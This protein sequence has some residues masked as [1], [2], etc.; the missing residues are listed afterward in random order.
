MTIIIPTLNICL[1]ANSRLSIRLNTKHLKFEEKKNMKQLIIF[2]L[3]F[4]T[5][6]A[7]TQ[8]Y[9]DTLHV[10]AYNGVNLRTQPHTSSKIVDAIPFGTSLMFCEDSF[11][12]RFE[13]RNGK[14]IE[15][16]YNQISCF[17]FDGF[18]TDKKPPRSRRLNLNQ[19]RNYI[20][21]TYGQTQTHQVAE[22]S[23]SLG[24]KA[25]ETIFHFSTG[26]KVSHKITKNQASWKYTFQRLR[27][28]EL[29]NLLDLAYSNYNKDNNTL[30]HYFENDKF[31]KN[32]DPNDI[33]PVAFSFQ[34]TES[35][36]IAYDY[37]RKRSDEAPLPKIY[38]M[39]Q[40][41]N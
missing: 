32:S 2:T 34:L 25:N 40:V 35:I 15:V 30:I 22:K 9:G 7:L 39:E 31:W 18:L 11:D 33:C 23:M 20:E 1:L 21:K 14:W 36:R 16:E 6:S 28:R 3:L 37:S 5:Q 41:E 8:T 27:S 13:G 10:M 12:D 19:L 4:L 26:L 29:M 24:D 17:V 38:I